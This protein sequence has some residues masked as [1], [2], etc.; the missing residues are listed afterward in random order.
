MVPAPLLEARGVLKR[1]GETRVLDGADLTLFPGEIHVLAG[2]NGAGKSTLIKI[3][4]GIVDAD[5]GTLRFLDQAKASVVHQ[6]LSLVESL[7][8]YE[9]LFLGREHQASKDLARTLLA[10]LDLRCSIDQEVGT[11]SLSEKSRLE[12]AKALAFPTRILILDEPTT[13]LNQ[14]ETESLFALLRE[15]RGA[16]TAIVYI[17][18]RLREIAALADRITVLRDGKTAGTALYS[19]ITEGV[20]LKWMVGREISE[21]FPKRVKPEISKEAKTL[22]VQNLSA[23]G[24]EPISFEACAGEILGF[25][26]LQG[27]GMEE[28]LFSLFGKSGRPSGS[29]TLGG[30]A[31]DLC[32]PA[33]AIREGLALLT[34][35]RKKDGLILDH[36]IRKN[37]SLPTLPHFSP[38]GFVNEKT[39]SNEVACL[40]KRL[41]LKH[42][43]LEQEVRTLSGG[44]QQKVALAKWMLTNPEVLLLHEPTRGVDVGAKQEIY[45]WIFEESKKGKIILLITTEMPELLALSDRILVLHRGRKT[46]EFASTEATQEK[47]LLAALGGDENRWKEASA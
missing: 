22:T 41:H 32:S 30:R 7:T 9:N 15:L 3:L 23:P 17:S 18:H 26:G 16:G 25:A 5:G 37:A 36:S 10:R 13:A 34:A 33:S 21:H 42:A 14:T 35:E 8:V 20:F 47:L 27:S 4:A 40:A 29:I 44:N 2:E 31:V 24:L 12:I 45:E 46:A 43:S 38:L 11:L 19:D 6:E 39:E 28:I 1:Y